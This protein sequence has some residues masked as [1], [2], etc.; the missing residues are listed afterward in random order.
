MGSI[1]VILAIKYFPSKV[2]NWI[3]LVRKHVKTGNDVVIKGAIFITGHGAIS[4]D[5]GVHINSCRAS[6]PIGGD[7]KTVV[8]TFTNGQVH[9]GAN[10]GISNSALVA[11]ERIDIGKN[12]K[13]GGG[14]QIFD[15]DFHS[16]DFSTRTSAQD[17]QNIGCA[18]VIIKDGAF[19]GARCIIL[20]GVEIGEHSI[21][22]AGSVVTKNIPDNEIWGG[23]PA[24]FIRKLQVNA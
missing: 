2:I 8:N 20:K 7:T 6:N 14:T 23:N 17:D 3:T 16:L 12:V 10:S 1:S 11:R 19:I 24:K 22:G 15:N 13:I 9:I 18:P 21:V 4:L 5:D